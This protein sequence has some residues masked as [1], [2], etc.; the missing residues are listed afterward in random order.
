MTAVAAARRLAVLQRHLAPCQ[1]LLGR[2]LASSRNSDGLDAYMQ[3]GWA[4]KRIMKVD[5]EDVLPERT[6]KGQTLFIT[7][8]SRGIGLA[9][10]KRAAQDGANVVVVA[11]TAEPHPKLPGTVFTAA[12]EIEEAGGKALPIVC[13]IRDYEQVEAAV[14]RA[15]EHFGGIDILVNNASAINL[16]DTETVDMKRYDLMHSINARGTFACTKACL[17]H[18]KKGKN[19]HV[20]TLS[21]PL[22]QLQAKWFKHHVAYSAA[23]YGMSMYVMGHSA[24]FRKFGIAVN[25]LWPRTTIATAAVKN[26][27]GG[28]EMISRSRTPEIMA[29]AAHAILTRK[30]HVTGNFF[31]DDEVLISEGTTEL[32]KY[33]VD[34]KAAQHELTPDFFV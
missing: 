30:A 19:P 2:R 23:K 12:K 16:T 25:A 28:S 24:E 17:P 26:V 6:L 9:I 8:A 10:G 34:P 29:D 22:D 21:P 14:A 20:L 27:L 33:N 5:P 4:Q 15:V 1:P 32:S 13:D 3:G 31:V 7:G 18:L 11:K